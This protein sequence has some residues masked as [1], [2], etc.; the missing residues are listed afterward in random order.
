M[1][2]G[3]GEQGGRGLSW[4]FIY[5]TNTVDKG[6]KVLFFG[7]LCYFL[8][9]FFVAPHIPWKRLNSAIFRSFL[10]FFVL[11][12]CCPPPPDNFLPTLLFLVEVSNVGEG[13]VSNKNDTN[14]KKVKASLALF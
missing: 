11:F 7:V 10:L 8:V 6:L 3:N 9:F 13:D 5:G 1:G 4:I 14:N 12:F 2:V